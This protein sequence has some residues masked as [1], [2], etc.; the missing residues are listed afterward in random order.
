M[1][2]RSI[3]EQL[4]DAVRAELDARLVRNGF[5]DYVGL[6]DWLTAQGYEIKKSALH[7]Y[8]QRFEDRCAALKIATQQARAIV[9]E[10]PDDEGAMGE[11]LTRLV[12]EKIFN[13][14][15]DLQVDPE[16]I[17]LSKLTRSIA[18]LTRSSVTLKKYA[19]EVKERAQAAADTAS[20]IAKKGGLSADAAAEIR[21]AILGVAK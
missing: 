17:D 10:T 5:A 16:T 1:P 13:V 20:K 7:A 12:Q 6:A 14:L 8:G 2:P 9:A 3:V 21:S 15:M 19:R 18:E 4:P 11:A